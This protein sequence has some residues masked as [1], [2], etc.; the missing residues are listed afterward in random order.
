MAAAKAPI[1]DR[2]PR[3]RVDKF[4]DRRTELAE[5]ALQTLAE[6]GYSRTS[7]REIA[8]NSEFSHGVLHYYFSDKVDLITCSVRLYKARC[9]TRYDRVIAEA[10]GYT[11]L[12]DGFLDIFGE[13][14]RNEASLHRL[15]YDLRSQALYDAAFRPDV[16]AIEQ[17]LEDMIWRVMTRLEQLSGVAS[18]M[19][20]S[21]AC[22][23]FDGL[24]QKSLLKYLSGDAGAV[25]DLR[26][27]ARSVLHRIFGRTPETA[28]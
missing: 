3:H 19:Q 7:L 6:L 12:L 22:A 16:A 15:W 24:F 9:V 2:L 17:S 21:L 4:V 14:L 26:H 23:I 13:T 27:N 1:L 28:R 10:A 18:S 8:E 20:P 11:E 25:D 5:S